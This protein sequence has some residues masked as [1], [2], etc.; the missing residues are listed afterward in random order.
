M[1]YSIETETKEEAHKTQMYTCMQ[2]TVQNKLV[3]RVKF[4]TIYKLHQGVH[5]NGSKPPYIPILGADVTSKP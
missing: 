3:D 5:R 1:S 2:K 4:T